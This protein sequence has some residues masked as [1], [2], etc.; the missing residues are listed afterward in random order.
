[1]TSDNPPQ[2]LTGPQNDNQRFRGE[3]PDVVCLS[4]DF[5][6]NYMRRTSLYAGGAQGIPRN[7]EKSVVVSG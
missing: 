2:K 1:M 3:G 5:A 6:G 4:D 7:L